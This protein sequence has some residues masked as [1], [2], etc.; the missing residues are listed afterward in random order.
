MARSE[1]KRLATASGIVFAVL[2]LSGCNS[3]SQPQV[4][5]TPAAPEP[6]AAGVVGTAI[7]QSLD[8]E[9]RATAI[10]AQNDAVNS[11]ARKTWRGAHGTY[12][13]IEPGPEGVTCRDY[14]HK[15][16]INGR[17][18]EGRGQACRKSEGGWRVT[19]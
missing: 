16:F 1:V 9:D 12:G 19:S 6:P 17:P 4:A 15:I 13:F 8:S 2:F 10:A 11:G 3:G 5:A 7:G 18:Q 14:T